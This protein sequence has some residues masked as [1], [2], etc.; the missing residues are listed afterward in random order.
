[1]INSIVN[2]LTDLNEVNKVKIL[3]DGNENEEFKEI[4]TRQNK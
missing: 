2:T 3:I 4:Y 1:M